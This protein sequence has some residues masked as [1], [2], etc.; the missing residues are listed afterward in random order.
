MT[1]RL[2][3]C[4]AVAAATL[5]APAARAADPAPTGRICEWAAARTATASVTSRVF[6]GGPLAA[7]GST[8]SMRCSV[9]AGNAVHSGPAVFARSSVPG[10][11][12]TVLEPGLAPYDGVLCT[13]ATVGATT[14]YWT[15]GGW[16]T[17]AGATCDDTPSWVVAALPPP[18]GNVA[19]GV[20]CLVVGDACDV[21]G[22]LLGS[23]PDVDP[24]LC[25]L[26]GG[27]LYVGDTLVWD[28]PP[29]G[30]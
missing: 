23:V 3:A 18:L 28:C 9:H 4:A 5:A 15:F 27:D 16:T 17:D 30:T 12:V 19:D 11:G 22:P 26:L 20:L 6:G 2:L 7:S 21:I 14:W 29:Y 8:V 10:P 1:P 13:E 25:P 24:V